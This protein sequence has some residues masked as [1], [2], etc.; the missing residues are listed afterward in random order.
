M[1]VR[2]IIQRSMLAALTAFALSSCDMMTE[3]LSDCPTGLYVNF[4]YD[5]NIQRADMFKDHVGGLTLYVYDESDHLVAQRTVSG[6]EL[7]RYGYYIHFTEQELA[8][9][10]TYR[11]QAVAMQK[12]WAAALQTPGAKYRKTEMANGDDRKSFTISLDRQKATQP[13]NPLANYYMPY[14]E[15]SAAAPLDTLWH[16]L[17]TLKAD[18]ANLPA[19]TQYHQ[20][21]SG[22]VQTNGVETI[23]VVSGEPTYATV[24]L[25]RDTNHLNLSLREIDNPEKVNHEDYDVTIIDDNPDLDYENNVI[26]PA[27]SIIYRPYAQW[28][29]TVESDGQTTADRSAHYDLMFNRLRYNTTASKNAVLCIRKKATGEVVALFNLPYILCQGR[30]AYEIN[31]YQPQEYLDR[32]YDYRLEL[33]L[34]GERWQE[35][36]YLLICVHDLPWVMRMQYVTL[37]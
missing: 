19:A 36:A 30:M 7:N 27:D 9:D 35:G 8:P 1:N 16:T 26:A 20:L 10:H 31:A 12:D 18:A 33:W 34:K 3:D 28:T 5:Y 17:T 32:E 4:V 15:V 29:S 22:G 6:S 13:V 11:L 2:H 37:Q 24:S 23:T 25:I 14:Y 21:A